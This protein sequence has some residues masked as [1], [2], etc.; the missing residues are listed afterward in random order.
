MKKIILLE[1]IPGS[2]KSTIARFLSIQ[3]ERNGQR[4]ILFHETTADHPILL[5]DTIIDPHEWMNTYLKNWIRFLEDD[6]YDGSIIVM[7]SVLFQN[8]ILN[9]LNKD[10]D[11]PSIQLFIERLS[12]LISNHEASLIFFYQ[13]DAL[14]YITQMIENRGGSQFLIQKYEEYKD[15]KYYTN[16]NNIGPELHLDFLKDYSDISKDVIKKLSIKTLSI[17]NSKKEWKLYKSQILEQYNL[18]QIL[19]P[20]FSNDELNRFVGTFRNNE[21]NFNIQIEMKEGHLYIFGNRKLKCRKKNTFYL[22]DMSV[23]VS[24]IEENG[25]YKE[26][27][28]G[29]KDIF[30]NRNE[31][32]TAFERIS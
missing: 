28:I 18:K 5:R 22:D 12:L 30:A 15:E 6:S 14:S 13:Q 32:G 17:E 21:M 1:G 11:K 16:R 2:G 4:P 23:E 7:E 26:I 29:E 31:D 27:V 8:P 10:F 25:A 24:F 19:D 20:F 3:L 9:L